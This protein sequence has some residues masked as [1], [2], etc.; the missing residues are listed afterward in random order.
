ML[1]GE[2]LKIE[3]PIS[4]LLY[5]NINDELQRLLITFNPKLK[6]IKVIAEQR[7]DE[8]ENALVATGFSAGV[9]TFTTLSLFT[10]DEVPPQ[11]RLNSLTTFD[12]G[13]MGGHQTSKDLYD[14][15]RKRLVDYAEASGFR[16]QALRTNVDDF[17]KGKECR[18]RRTHTL[19]N[20]AAA[21]F[22][23]DVF[24]RYLYSSAFSYID[25]N[26]RNDDMAFIDPLLLP[27]L[28]SEKMQMKSS[29]AGLARIEKMRIVASYEP[30]KWFLDVCVANPRVRTENGRVNCSKCWKCSRAMVNLDALGVLDE[31]DNV[32][33]ISNYRYNKKK[34]IN[35]VIDKSMDR[36]PQDRDVLKMLTDQKI[37]SRWYIYMRYL[38]TF[39]RKKVKRIKL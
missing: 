14:K 25:I 26:R 33:N 21:F 12:V 13:A 34:Y 39:S 10:R 29:G 27:L 31:F 7:P 8:G 35:T 5:Y 2:D 11:L 24:C 17:Y 28:S 36:N 23:G 37:V 18:F 4:T 38:A 3:G 6:P 32:F 15:Y 1:A 30:C 9:D 22:F 16:W 20:A 19:R